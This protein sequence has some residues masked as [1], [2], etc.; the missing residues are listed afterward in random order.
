MP[1]ENVSAVED[2]IFPLPEGLHRV[3][4][5]YGGSSTHP[6]H[7]LDFRIDEIPEGYA[8]DVR[9]Y[10]YGEPILATK[11][12]IVTHARSFDIRHGL[13]GAER[14]YG[15]YV[16]IKHDDG[17][18][19]MYAHMVHNSHVRYVTIGDRVEA[20]QIIGALGDTGNVGG[21]PRL[22]NGEKKVCPESEAWA[23]HLHFAVYD[24]NPL[25]S[26]STSLV[27]EP[28]GHPDN[29]DIDIGT[30]TSYTEAYDK[31]NLY[32]LYDDSQY[33]YDLRKEQIFSIT[34]L[35]V[36]AG[37]TVTFQITGEFFT[38]NQ[39]VFQIPF[40]TSQQ[41]SIIDP[42][43]AEVTCTLQNS[44]GLQEGKFV[45]RK[46]AGQIL[47]YQVELQS[48]PSG[49]P[50]VDT[51]NFITPKPGEFLEMTVLGRNF[52]G[53]L[54]VDVRSS[55]SNDLC[56]TTGQAS[57]LS[58]G[59]IQVRCQLP[60]NLGPVDK[61]ADE[62]FTIRVYRNRDAFAQREA[63]LYSSDTEV[64]YGIAGADLSPRQA[65]Y[66]FQTRFTITGRNVH[67]TSVFFIEGCK[68]EDT[69]VIYQN[70]EKV[71]FECI[72]QTKLGTDP[73][74][75]EGKSF[76]HIFYFK[77][78]S[79]FNE[80]GQN[81][82]SDD[83][84]RQ[85]VIISGYITVT[86]DTEERI[87]T[88]SPDVA[89][90]GKQTTFT[91]KGN[92]LP[93]SDAQK[94]LVWLE[95]CPGDE[96][97]GPIQIIPDS[98]TPSTFDFQCLPQFN[99]VPPNGKST[100]DISKAGVDG[101]CDTI[102]EQ[103][104]SEA[105]KNQAFEKCYDTDNRNIKM[106]MWGYFATFFETLAPRSLHVKKMVGAQKTLVSE[107]K[108]KFISALY[109]FIQDEEEFQFQ[110]QLEDGPFEDTG[111]TVIKRVLVGEITRKNR[112]QTITVLGESMPKTLDISSDE[113]SQIAKT[114]R[115]SERYEF[116]C[117]LKKVSVQELVVFDQKEGK[118]LSR[119]F[120]D[121]VEVY[122]I[123]GN[124]GFG[125]DLVKLEV[126]GVNLHPQMKLQSADCFSIT[127][128][129][130]PSSSQISYDCQRSA[131]LFSRDGDLHLKI[132]SK[133]DV[134]LFDNNVNLSRNSSFT[135]DTKVIP[136]PGVPLVVPT[137]PKGDESSS[138][139]AFSTQDPFDFG[140]LKLRCELSDDQDL[141]LGE[142]EASSPF[143]RHGKGIAAVD[144]AKS[145]ATFDGRFDATF[146]EMVD[147]F[148]QQKLKGLKLNPGSG[149]G[150]LIADGEKFQVM[151][152]L[153]LKALGFDL[154]EMLGFPMDF[155]LI[156]Y[157]GALYFAAPS[158]D[159]KKPREQ[160]KIILGFGP[161]MGKTDF[162]S[163]EAIADKLSLQIKEKVAQM[164]ASLQK[165][166]IELGAKLVSSIH[167]YQAKKL[168][169]TSYIKLFKALEIVPEAIAFYDNFDFVANGKL[170]SEPF[171][172]GKWGENK[173]WIAELN[174]A[175]V[176]L[177]ITAKDATLE[178]RGD[179][180]NSLSIL[181]NDVF[182]TDR[183][184]INGAL[185]VDL[186]QDNGRIHL[187]QIEL[188]LPGD[189]AKF[190]VS[191]HLIRV[192][193]LF[194]IAAWGNIIGDVTIKGIKFIHAGA[195]FFYDPNADYT[196]DGKKTLGVLRLEIQA[197]LVA[198]AAQGKAVFTS[199][200]FGKLILDFGGA[201]DLDF[202]GYQKRIGDALGRL[203]IDDEAL[204]ACFNSETGQVT[205]KIPYYDSIPLLH[206][207]AD[208]TITIKAGASIET[209]LTLDPDFGLHHIAL[210]GQ[211]NDSNRI[212]FR[213]DQENSWLTAFSSF[214]QTCSDAPGQSFLNDVLALD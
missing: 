13:P 143:L 2:Y 62:P 117:L 150:L 189:F 103:S 107:Q 39:K 114:Y 153:T 104:W 177:D 133:D 74:S 185:R 72:I 180:I 112:H 105:E 50:V 138:L 95:H 93:Y 20:G 44:S 11:A 154:S 195:G 97:G 1:H 146:G 201:L 179:F 174:L 151:A 85:N 15:N 171:R 210:S 175:K 76:Q 148:T 149:D 60:L 108:V 170:K 204:K 209:E 147:E 8:E 64:N 6:G 137:L 67:R 173:K 36:P 178:L 47:T 206:Y 80:Q 41:V 106:S 18:Q 94:P 211:G 7:E 5:G 135:V 212:G 166:K 86:G 199:P 55:S 54:Y 134:L 196:V 160:S 21:G 200:E 129:G 120:T 70:Y 205:F 194:E 110:Y 63:P 164:N 77:T 102:N 89:V 188:H 65:S 130:E 100:F 136:M 16:I 127:M 139:S 52:P 213:Y 109:Q 19:S 58:P 131:G 59:K 208:D 172:P 192:F 29:V 69:K 144:K 31:D 49:N 14:S 168:V 132:F 71:V 182:K 34:P 123:F 43:H 22:P 181:N 207:F 4:N 90:V 17:E 187:D 92:N 48:S 121:V 118:E 190:A 32:F 122:D 79:R 167:N 26:S 46:L 57:F 125:D 145:L 42:E 162:P 91:V 140:I 161:N 25:L 197:A 45:N 35:Q 99:T 96:N 9:C 81:I 23:A 87:D 37:Q 176:D 111:P 113:C 73:N 193:S 186:A 68:K 75:V 30:I 56:D 124:S 84:D 66:G 159:V 3:T 78:R 183:G 116:K 115:S 82:L 33:D 214:N 10:T 152:D 88:V 184:I 142:C 155:D 83:E 198:L 51:V 126:T 163:L 38:D 119:S 53:D 157:S 98:F 169:R 61:R 165:K 141:F 24:G 101:F 12:G 40:C 128:Q 158:F 156:D 203:R 28:L 191:L 202:L 27:P